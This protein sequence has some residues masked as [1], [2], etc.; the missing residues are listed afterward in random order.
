MTLK[1]FATVLTLFKVQ[2]LECVDQ[3]IINIQK[4][5]VF[6]NWNLKLF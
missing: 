2:N 1:M 5:K 4:V 3:I 6:M